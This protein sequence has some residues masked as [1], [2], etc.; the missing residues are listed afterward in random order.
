[1]VGNCFVVMPFGQ[2][3]DER[4]RAI[5]FDQIYRHLIQPAIEG[6]SELQLRPLRSDGIT[7]PGWIHK[8]MI[9]HLAEDEVVLVD[10]STSNSNVMYELGVRHALRGKVTVLIRRR[11][12]KLPLHVSGFRVIDYDLDPVSLGQ[13]KSAIVQAIKQGRASADPDS[14]VHLLLDRSDRLPRRSGA[15]FG[16]MPFE[17]TLG[18]TSATFRE[19]FDH[20]VRPSLEDIRNRYEVV[21]IRSDEAEGSGVIAEGIFA[22]L[23][24]D[25]VVVVDLSRP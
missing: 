21:W 12:T 8:Q 14:P 6:T 17:D 7:R 25:T 5:D 16:I 9:E 20:M 19:V 11:G 23:Q 3:A 13:A 1:M 10:L 4:G 24:N 18:Q 15:W 2:K 22:H